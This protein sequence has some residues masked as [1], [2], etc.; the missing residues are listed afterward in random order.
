MNLTFVLLCLPAIGVFGWLGW[1]AYHSRQHTAE[2]DAELEAY[3]PTDRFD[4]VLNPEAGRDRL[5]PVPRALE[6][7]EV[8]CWVAPN[9]T[10]EIGNVPLTRGLV[11]VGA[12]MYKDRNAWLPYDFLIDP[13]LPVNLDDPDREGRTVA[14]WA[15]YNKLTPNARAAFLLWLADGAQAPDA[16][17]GFVMMYAQ[18]LRH[19]ISHDPSS[20]EAQAIRD[21]MARLRVTYP[22]HTLAASFLE[23]PAE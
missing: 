7:P 15:S 17:Q 11:Y 5:K 6:Q 14:P 23:A 16:V 21:E 19:R 22:Q 9:E 20:K 12:G 3:T 2:V 1:R 18:G 10:V 13:T 8:L 4:I